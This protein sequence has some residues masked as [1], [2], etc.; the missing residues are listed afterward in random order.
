MQARIKELT[1]ILNTAIDSY[2]KDGVSRLS[3][4]DFDMLMKELQKLEG[5]YPEHLDPNSP[6]QRVGSDLVPGF[7]KVSHE[8]TMLSIENA[9]TLGEIESFLLTTNASVSANLPYTGELKIDGLSLAVTYED[10]KLLRAVTRGDG[11]V[12]D[13]VT[14]NAKTITDIPLTLEGTHSGILEARGEVYMAK[15]TLRNINV[16]RLAA[17]E[18]AFQNPRNSAA[19]SL[20][21]K[22]VLEVAR[23]GLR[24]KAFGIARGASHVTSQSGAVAFLK[25]S[26][27]TNVNG[28]FSFK[29]M[30]EFKAAAEK[31][32]ASRDRLPFDIDGLVVKVDDVESRKKLGS[33]G[34]VIRWACAYKFNAEQ[35]RTQLLAKTYQVGR[36]GKI[37]P[38]AELEPVFLAG[39]TIKRATLH[40]FDEVARLGVR[41]GDFVYLEKGGDV[42]PKIVGVDLSARPDTT[43]DFDIPTVCP[44]CGAPLVKAGDDVDLRCIDPSCPPQ[45]QRRIEHFVSRD[46]MDVK[47]M[48]ESI[49]AALLDKN[50]VKTPLDLYDLGIEDFATVDRMGTK[51]ATK[52]SALI[53]ASKQNSG[54]KLLMGLGIRHVGKGTARRLLESFGDLLKV[55]EAPEESLSIVRDVGDVAAKSIKKWVSENQDSIAKIIALGINTLYIAPISSTGTS[56]SGMT[57]VVTGTLS[58]K[59]SEIEDMIKAAGGTPSDSVSKKTRYLVCGAEPGSKLEKANKLGVEVIDEAKLLELINK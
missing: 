51:T 10:G 55:F 46:C 23:R 9:Y 59:R 44:A 17:G 12:G 34:K 15:D 29:T 14:E 47:H 49:V 37:T 3:D 21:T 28:V 20:K 32:L 16:F 39:S 22:D 26:G 27:F 31:V 30:D 58:K 7:E 52:L 5:Q 13:D 2:Y 54:E 6:S 1:G 18:K 53:D 57:F 19:G 42:I 56:L 48:G 50:L 35:G 40:N 8:V 4:Q 25:E 43:E 45:V 33:T 36:T 11:L 38:V 41:V 24:F